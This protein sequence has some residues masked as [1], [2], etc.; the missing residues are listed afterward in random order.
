MGTKLGARGADWLI[1]Q[2]EL[3]GKPDNITI[4][5]DTPDTAV[6]LGLVKRLYAFTPVQNLKIDTDFK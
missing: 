5:C 4:H 6:L 3:Y 1:K 2:V